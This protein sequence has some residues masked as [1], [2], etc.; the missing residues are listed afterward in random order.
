MRPIDTV[1]AWS[2]LS[3]H[4]TRVI[5]C[6]V[7]VSVCLLITKWLNRSRCRFG[8]GLRWVQETMCIRWRPRSP[9]KNGNFRGYIEA[10]SD[11]PRSIKL[12]IIG[13]CV[14]H[15]HGLSSIHFK[16]IR[17]SIL[18]SDSRVWSHRQS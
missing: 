15:A 12:Q 10:C 7:S 1:V 5:I 17:S 16:V 3:S 18:F 8:C 2:Q 6:S 4:A 13:Q 9:Q 11:L 14:L